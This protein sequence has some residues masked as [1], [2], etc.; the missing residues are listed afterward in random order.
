[1]PV[2]R[3]IY[4]SQG[5][6][7]ITFTCARWLKLFELTQSYDLVYNWFNYLKNQN[8]HIVG[9]VIMPNHVHALIAFSNSEKSI[10]SIVGNGKRFIAYELV[11]RLQQGKFTKELELLSGWVNPTDRSRNKKHEVFEPSFDWKECYDEKLVEQKLNYIHEN[12]SKG[13]KRLVESPDDYEHS[14]ARF[15]I[16]GQKGVVEITS[17]LE[18]QDVDLT[19]PVVPKSP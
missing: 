8:H 1:M 13:E 14:S 17:W 12:A 16:T 5:I 10:N 9:Y 11:K 6:Y 3:T 7:F 15:Y 2:R 4:E 19:R 18:L